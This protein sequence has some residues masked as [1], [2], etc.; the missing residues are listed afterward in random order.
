MANALNGRKGQKMVRFYSLMLIW[1][2]TGALLDPVTAHDL[3]PPTDAIPSS[4]FGLHIHHLAYPVPTPWPNMPVPEWRIWDA[5]VTWADIE[6][7][8]GQWQFEKLDGYVALAKQ[9]GTGVLLTLGGSPRWASAR[10]D[11]SSP[12]Y[13]GFAAE[14]ASIEDW[15]TY[16]KTVVTRYKG[17]I[18]GYEVWNEPN[19]ND[20]WSGTTDQ[21]MTLTKE[22]SLIIRSVDPKAIIVSPSATADFGI[23]WLA[24][25][26]KKGGGQYVDV[27]GFHFYV[28]PHTLLPEDMLPVIQRV[29]ELLAANGLSNR[30]IWNTETGWLPP[31]KFD[32]NELA[33]GFLARA[34]ILSWAAGIQ[35]FY[36]YAWDNQYTAIVTYNETTR[37]VTPAGNAYGVIQ[38]WLVGAKIDSCSSA[39]DQTWSCELTRSG[40]KEWIVWNTQGNRQFDV[41]R[42][43]NVATATRLLQD[44]HALKG[45]TAEIAPV[46]T[47]FTRR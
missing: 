22:A 7:S 33:A 21:M 19:L 29:H 26:L 10:P 28:S 42:G 12:Y 31:A 8:K 13:P 38:Q 37:S 11:A 43:W 27:I 15:R 39:P 32:S 18:Q 5:V 2:L 1:L 17:R 34:Y 14:P 25:F 24:E 35:R 9:H 44:A 41:P 20:F 36:W 47:L 6:P 3:F 16:V 40:K 45:T 30:P 46:P 23:P 4:Y